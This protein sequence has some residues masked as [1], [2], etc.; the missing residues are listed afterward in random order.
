MEDLI[1]TWDG[2]SVITRY[3][4]GTSTWMFIAIHSTALGTATGGTR[5]KVYSDPKT[6]LQDT[7]RLAEG[8]TYKW[9][10]IKF[11]CGGGKA[12]L[13]LSRELSSG[14]RTALLTRYGEWLNNLGGIFETGPDLG[15]TPADMDLI[16]QGYKGV[17][18]CTPEAGGQGDPGPYTAL[19][20]FSGIQSSCD[21]VF[22]THELSDRSV[23]V[24]GVGSVGAPLID[25]LLEADCNVIISDIDTEKVEELQAALDVEVVDPQAIYK[26]PCDVFA[27]CATGG[28]L[29]IE[30]I[31][32]LNCK[33]VAGGANNQLARPE[34]AARLNDRGI[35]YAPDFIINAGGALYLLSIES[36]GWTLEQARNEILGFGD[37][38]R[39]IYATADELEIDTEQAAEEL[40]RRRILAAGKQ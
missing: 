36:M 32:N 20:V 1:K 12:V 26:K 10:G 29:N 35:L 9:A 39:E 37:T 15:T 18:G 22:G 23:L 14:D 6:A 13:G 11:P 4:A 7:M 16:H 40:A 25:Y 3:D 31:P 27:P 8:M 34:D 19:G 24:Q 28:I 30:T 2:E 5:L 33:I 17:F 21:Y 38:L